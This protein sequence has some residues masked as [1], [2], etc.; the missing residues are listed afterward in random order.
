MSLVIKDKVFEQMTEGLHNVIITEVKDLGLQE[1]QFGTKDR[2]R[3]VFQAQDQK[4]SKTGEA[5]NVFMTC[6]KS[7]HSKSALGKLL[8]TL[9]VPAGAEFDLNDLTGIKCQVVVQHKESEG[10]TY[11]NIV[12]VLPNKK[13]S[14]PAA[15]NF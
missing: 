10:K 4:D 12:S 9:K 8:N 14:A 3:I 13:S 1:T 15:E 7:L 5:I 2:A 6:T 11:A